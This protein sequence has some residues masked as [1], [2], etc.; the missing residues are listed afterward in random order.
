MAT[1][2]SDTDTDTDDDQVDLF[3]TPEQLPDGLRKIV[4]KYTEKLEVSEEDAYEVCK[5]FL[6]KVEHSGYTFDYG[7]D[8]VPFNLREFD[9][10]RHL[11]SGPGM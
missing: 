10:P 7:L 5:K 4:S 3:E 2:I 11:P 1:I 8:G 9:R 6:A